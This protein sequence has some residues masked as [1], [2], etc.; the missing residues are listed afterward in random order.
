[1][2]TRLQ[3]DEC[4][5]QT[6]H[7]VLGRT[8]DEI[9][10][11]VLEV[12]SDVVAWVAAWMPAEL[13]AAVGVSTKLAAAAQ[14]REQLLQM[15]ADLQEALSSKLEQALQCSLSA[16]QLQSEPSVA[17]VKRV[18]GKPQLS[19][20]LQQLGSQLCQQLPTPLFCN[21]PGCGNFVK[22]SELQLARG[23]GCVCSACLTAHYC[24]RE[25]QSAHWQQHKQVCKR[26]KQPK[27]PTAVC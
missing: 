22:D 3:Q 2:V 21:N 10:I 1:M 13:P 19:E 18:W 9:A 25:C 23:K 6:P 26:L 12:C 20:Q 15:L 17:A 14:A 5:Q 27:A 7:E 24:G 11:E 16:Q 8:N 4:S